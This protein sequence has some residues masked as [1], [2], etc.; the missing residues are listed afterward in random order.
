MATVAAAQN[1]LCDGVAIR[2]RRRAVCGSRPEHPARLAGFD[3]E[4]AELIARELNRTPQFVQVTF[5]SLDQ[6]AARGDFF[7]LGLSG[8]EDTPGV[9]PRRGQHSVLPVSG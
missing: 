7:D 5:T 2:R 8:I 3:V 4:I 6:S 9:A 1:P